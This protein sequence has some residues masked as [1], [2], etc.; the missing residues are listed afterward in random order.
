M[1]ILIAHELL[2]LNN[3]TTIMA[4]CSFKYM[5]TK[6][7]YTR[8][9]LVDLLNVCINYN[10]IYYILDKKGEIYVVYILTTFT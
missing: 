2:I 10:D 9:L 4:F 8:V 3:I 5:F 6:R 1:K 7:V